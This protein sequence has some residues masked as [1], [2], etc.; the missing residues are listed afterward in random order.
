M[1]RDKGITS[2]QDAEKQHSVT[3]NVLQQLRAERQWPKKA[4][5][6][7]TLGCDCMVHMLVVVP[8][9]IAKCPQGSL[10]ESTE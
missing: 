4:C 6:V 5:S 3:P 9:Q 2:A 10:G 8:I 7:S 1:L